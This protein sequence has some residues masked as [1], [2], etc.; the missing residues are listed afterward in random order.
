MTVR[1]LIEELRK[2]NPDLT[3]LVGVRTPGTDQ[4]SGIEPEVI[5][6]AVDPSFDIPHTVWVQPKRAE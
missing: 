2:Y 1:H 5:W 3:V 4:I 6:T